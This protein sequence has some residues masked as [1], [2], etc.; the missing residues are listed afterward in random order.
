MREKFT[1]TLFVVLALG[2]GAA[3]L[4]ST[5]QKSNDGNKPVEVPIAETA[6]RPERPP[7]IRDLIIVDSPEPGDL[8]TNPLV[9]EGRAR[10]TWYFEGDFPVKLLDVRGNL[11]ATGIAMAQGEWMTEDYVPFTVTLEFVVPETKEGN[12]VFERNNPSDL[13]ENSQKF[14]LPV[15]FS[16]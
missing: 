8:I 9:I 10:G 16:N 11:L 2:I 4:I 15:K 1:F 12:L 3:L 6:P 14:E 13:P 7:H 5:I